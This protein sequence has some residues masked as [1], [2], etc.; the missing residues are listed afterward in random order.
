MHS[1]SCYDGLKHFFFYDSTKYSFCCTS[2]WICFYVAVPALAGKLG[3]L[4]TEYLVSK[5]VKIIF[6]LITRN[7]KE[8]APDNK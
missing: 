2:E 3:I 7:D 5:F 1:V 8:K 4:K 6:F